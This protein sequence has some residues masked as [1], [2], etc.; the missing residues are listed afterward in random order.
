MGASKDQNGDWVTTGEIDLHM[1]NARRQ[2]SIMDLKWQQPDP[3]TRTLVF[4]M[5]TPQGG[6]QWLY[7]VHDL[8]SEGISLVLVLAGPE[9]KNGPQPEDKDPG[10]ES[11][12]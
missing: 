12:E 6:D 4:G 3:K 11:E 5:E 8:T 9:V 10:E 7:I 1:E 2:G